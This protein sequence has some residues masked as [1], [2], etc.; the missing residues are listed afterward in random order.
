[1]SPHP[2]DAKSGRLEMEAVLTTDDWDEIDRAR[3]LAS[4]EIREPGPE[5]VLALL[6]QI[7][8]GGGRNQ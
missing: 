1:M 8:G 3:W 4:V 5:R 6:D 2:T 7:A